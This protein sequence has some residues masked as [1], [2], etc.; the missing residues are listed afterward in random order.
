[1]A[2]PNYG[3][4]SSNPPLYY[5]SHEGPVSEY[6]TIEPISSKETG[7]SQIFG[8]DGIDTSQP[9]I[10][11][12]PPPFPPPG[13]ADK[14]NSLQPFS[15]RYRKLIRITKYLIVV[16]FITAGLATPV[17]ISHY[18]HTTKERQKDVR[19]N[20]YL[21]L[22][23]TWGSACVSNVFINVFPYLFK[24]VA[25]VVNP[26]HVKYWRIFRFLRLAVTVLG[27]TIGSYISFELVSFPF[28]RRAFATN[29]R[30]SSSTIKT[31]IKKEPVINLNMAP[32]NGRISLKPLL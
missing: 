9:S 20:V 14:S 22:L 1:M 25:Q 27:A 16:A 7:E 5:P 19:Y 17:L 29:S 15:Q 4:S 18:R 6:I 32:S 12:L 8:T 28:L 11:Y 23:I 24:F 30:S 26:G 10:N 13:W 2:F 3:P 21:W 31:F